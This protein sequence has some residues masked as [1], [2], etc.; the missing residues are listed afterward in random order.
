MTQKILRTDGH[1]HMSLVDL[2]DNLITNVLRC[3]STREKCQA[4]LVCR[5]FREI[6]SHPTPGEFVWDILSL[7]DPPFQEA[8]LP[9]L[10]RQAPFGCSS[11]PVV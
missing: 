4:E 5:T 7:D 3:L 8:P 1:R 11:S 2:P 6:L 9:G 10:S